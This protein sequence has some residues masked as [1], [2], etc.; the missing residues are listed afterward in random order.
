LG[1]C[2]DSGCDNY[3]EPAKAVPI[4]REPRRTEIPPEINRNAKGIMGFYNYTTKDDDVVRRTCLLSLYVDELIT[5][6]GALNR[7]YVA[8]LGDPKSD[9]R[10]FRM[11]DILWGLNVSKQ[12]DPRIRE[13]DAEWLRSYH[14][15]ISKG[16]G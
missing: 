13:S 8:Q 14:Q 2:T 1:K 7:D 5:A 11:C 6:P 12:V 3:S 4:K 9:Q 10:V 15:N 16:R